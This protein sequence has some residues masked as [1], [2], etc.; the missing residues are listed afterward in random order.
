MKIRRDVT[1]S[2]TEGGDEGAT[3][4]KVRGACSVCK[5]AHTACDGQRPCK[6]CVGV[7]K[8]DQC[9]DVEPKKRACGP[10]RSAHTA[11]DSQRPCKRCVAAG[12][13]DLCVDP[14]LRK[15]GR[16][17]RSS[18]TDAA[19]WDTCGHPALAA[20]PP[21]PA[22]RQRTEEPPLACKVG[23]GQTVTDGAHTPPLSPLLPPP[24]PLPG[25]HST[26]GQHPH[27][28]FAVGFTGLPNGGSGIA[29]HN[30]RPI[31]PHGSPV[32][33]NGAASG[34]SSSPPVPLRPASP[35]E[36]RLTT[37]GSPLATVRAPSPAQRTPTG[38]RASSPPSSSASSPTSSPQAS[39]DD[40]ASSGGASLMQLE[41]LLSMFMKELRELKSSNEQVASDFKN[42]TEELRKEILLLHQNQQKIER[43]LDSLNSV[44]AMAPSSAP[45]FPSSP[46][47]QPHEITSYSPSVLFSPSDYGL[48][49]GPP[50]QPQQHS[51][52]FMASMFAASP[53]P[54]VPSPCYDSYF[55]RTEILSYLPFL[56]NYNLQS[57]EVPFVVDHLR[58]PFFALQ[59]MESMPGEEFTPPIFVYANSA[60]CS[61]VRYPLHELLGC[62]LSKVSFPDEKVK[63]QLLSSIS[64]SGRSI[65]LPQR[66]FLEAPPS[67]YSEVIRLS[68]LF[69]P[70]NGR[71]T[72]L[73]TRV[74]FFYNE[75]GRVKWKICC[76]DGVEESGVIE[77]PINWLPGLPK[78]WTTLPLSLPGLQHNG[79]PLP[80]PSMS[81][82]ITEEAKEE[83]DGD[84]PG[85][86]SPLEEAF[87]S[88][89]I[90]SPSPSPPPTSSDISYSP[91]SSSSSSATSSTSA[92]SCSASVAATA[93]PPPAWISSPGAGDGDA[94]Y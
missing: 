50:L 48:L 27:H 17:S 75:H 60:F 43:R 7:G 6:R 29:G 25:L 34:S 91:S 42:T 71:I 84:A 49:S 19:A 10:C 61:L 20:S 18:K 64:K 47:I 16:R 85:D 26:G 30:V 33:T 51:P 53:S 41:P 77:M 58:K 90:A 13:A 68:P 36:S 76:V 22:K 78:W 65:Y 86:S 15:K 28:P 67:S 24:F 87:L 82:R 83:V 39:R 88:S 35:D 44:V 57:P 66:G 38:S 54:G 14:E 62:P 21:T 4:T 45:S 70:R 59:I 3:D 63:R 37:I 73:S 32:P 1:T 9:F 74:Q 40:A 79:F 23:G 5:I 89:F 81:P 80:M 12:R 2:E 8:A 94:D 72:R 56:S 31:F 11:C 69:L 55:A 93:S 46:C 92:A 52:S